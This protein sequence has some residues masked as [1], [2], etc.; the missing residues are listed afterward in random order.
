MGIYR[1]VLEARLDA[2]TSGILHVPLLLKL[3]TLYKDS[4]QPRLLSL[5]TTVL[6]AGPMLLSHLLVLGQVQTWHACLLTE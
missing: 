6:R 3:F 5:H 4:L 1:A 2:L